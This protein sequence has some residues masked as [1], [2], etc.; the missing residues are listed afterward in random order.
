MLCEAT[1]V[2]GIT[3]EEIEAML[4]REAAGTEAQGQGRA[5]DRVAPGRVWVTREDVF[6][7]RIASAWLI[8]RFI[9]PEATF[10]FVPARGY[11]PAS[12]E[13]RF[14]MY[15]AEYTHEGEHCT[16]Q[17]LAARFGLTDKA[18]QAMGEVVHDIDCKDEMFGRPETRGVAAL[19]RGLADSVDSDAARVESGSA[20]FDNLYASFSKGS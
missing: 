3:D 15:Q 4:E 1:F 11:R 7:D 16:F 18:L 10:K 2:E 8:R 5:P 13:L 19:L 12:G 17:T 20:L 6:V 14:D 9:D